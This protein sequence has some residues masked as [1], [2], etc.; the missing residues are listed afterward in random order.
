MARKRAPRRFR[1]LILNPLSALTLGRA[2]DVQN[3]VQRRRAR[4]GVAIMPMQ[5][6]PRLSEVLNGDSRDSIRISKYQYP[7]MHW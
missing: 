5:V 3:T 4:D 2:P 6:S 7:G 1:G